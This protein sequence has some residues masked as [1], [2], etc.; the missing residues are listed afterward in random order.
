[1][2]VRSLLAVVVSLQLASCAWFR[3]SPPDYASV[4]L[5]SGVVVRD[6]VVPDAGEEAAPGDSV[7]IHYEVRLDD[8]SLVEA[9]RDGGE[10]L[11]FQ[12]GMG[13]VPE[14]LEQGLVGMRVFGR[15]RIVVPPEMAYGDEGR[16][17]AIPPRATLTFDVELM[18]CLRATEGTPAR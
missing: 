12:L 17:P 14:G 8:K 6:L 13:L 1:M 15:R 7:A 4:R 10:P 9:S 11:R 3:P 16:P 18:E 5:G 2:P